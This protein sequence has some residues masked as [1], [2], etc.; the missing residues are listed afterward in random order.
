MPRP[1]CPRRIGVCPCAVYFKPAGVP[2]RLL[3]E[4]ILTLDELESLR[5]AD[6]EGLYQEEA[7]RQMDISRPTF[8]R[9]VEQARRKVA[10]AL[11]HGRA[12]RLEG[13]TVVLKGDE[14]MPGKDGTG[15]LSKGRGQGQQTNERSA[16]G[17][18]K[19]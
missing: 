18:Q 12:L 15:P 16:K 9:V 5:L 4:V 1:C 11:V 7:A 17:G 6:L 8:A 2:L 13:G 10:Q 19:P 14:T 3:E